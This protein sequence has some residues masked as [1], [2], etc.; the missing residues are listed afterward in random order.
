MIPM[1]ATRWHQQ[2]KHV[3]CGSQENLSLNMLC[4]MYNVHLK[5]PFNDH[6]FMDGLM[7][8]FFACVF[9]LCRIIFSS[10]VESESICKSCHFYWRM[11]NLKLVAHW[12]SRHQHI[13]DPPMELTSWPAL[14][15]QNKSFLLIKLA[16]E[17]R[18]TKGFGDKSITLGVHFS[19]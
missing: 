17:V 11:S 16:M 14:Q 19:L 13:Q 18:G 4:L 5:P 8:S 10:S 7:S 1:K 2:V 15:V 3:V 12:L 6:G 9:K